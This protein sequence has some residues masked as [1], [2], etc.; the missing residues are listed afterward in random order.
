MGMK[1]W[2]HFGVA[3]KL[4]GVLIVAGLAALTPAALAQDPN[5]CDEPGEAPD[6]IV[7][8]L[9]Q[10]NSYGNVGEIYGYSVGTVSCNIGSCWL[11]WISETNEHPVIAQN[12]YR[13]KD[14]RLTHIGQSW[15]KHGFFALSQELCN[16]GC[17]SGG[18]SHLGVNCSDPYSASLNGQ[19]NRLGPRFEVNASTGQFAYPFTSEGQTGDKIY[20]R[21]QVHQDDLDPALN[22]GAL[23]FV[24]GHYVTHDD[25][26][27]NNDDNNAS[28]RQ[29]TVDPDTYNISLTGSTRRSKSAINAW[30]EYETG[31]STG[32]IAIPDDGSYLVASKVI[33][34]GG[35][36]SRF[37][38]AVQNLNSHRSAGAFWMPVPAGTTVTNIGFS[39]VDYHSGEP[40]DGTD[41]VGTHDPGTNLVEWRATQTYDENPN[42]NALRWGTMYS[43]WF[44]ADVGGGYTDVT[45]DLFRPGDVGDPVSGSGLVIAPLPCNNNGICEPGETCTNC[46][47]DCTGTIP[48][49]GFCGDGLCDM[50]LAE[51][52]VSCEADCAGVQSGNP[53][54]RYCCG[55]GGGQNPITCADPRCT[56]AGFDCGTTAAEACCGDDVCDSVED[57]CSCAADCG[58]PPE[59]ELVCNDG[60]DDDC[61]GQ[62][63]CG[64]LDCC[65]DALCIDGIDGDGDGV[66]DCDCDDGNN[67]VW[68]TPGEATDLSVSHDVG[69]GTTLDWASPVDTGSVSV[70]YETLRTAMPDNWMLAVDCVADGD[71]SDTTNLDTESP[72]PGLVFYYLVRASNACPAGVGPLGRDSGNAER[73]G[74]SCP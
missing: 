21:L 53:G 57:S 10:V 8:D 34:L 32:R 3:G 9:H 71:P 29:I 23:Y 62:A 44:D 31:V 68:A 1:D 26:G 30:G 7:G 38:F 25:A 74:A 66:A 55:A 40:F 52:C 35:G 6:V 42:A 58:A 39:D 64:D 46:L 67:Q 48:P 18:G 43:F 70:T 73:T 28:Y 50:A 33:D 41:W 19:Q 17:V 54:D 45:V 5:I 4:A 49:T 27:A 22:A 56:D 11:D 13:L 60:I 72:D 15:L 36:M 2:Q 20:K 51:D 16:E 63:D 47:N 59:S 65:T 24:E 12:M 69:V 37:E 61:D 14:G